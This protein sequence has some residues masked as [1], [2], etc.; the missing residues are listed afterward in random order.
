MKTIYSLFLL[1]C[2][3]TLHSQITLESTLDL[4]AADNN[5]TGMSVVVTCGDEVQEI[6]HHGLRNIEQNLPVNDDT[7]FRIAS[8]SKM[9]TAVGM[10]HLLDA[11]AYN[12]DDDVNEHLSFE[13]RNPAFPDTPITVRQVLSHQTGITDGDGYFDFLSAT[14]NAAEI[15]NL[16]ELLTPEG[17]YYT[18]DMFTANEAGTYFSYSNINSGLCATLLESISGERFDTY[19]KTNILEPLGIGGSFRVNDLT[20]LD[21]LS[22]LYRNGA[23]QWDNYQGEYPA[24]AD[25]SDY[26]PGTNGVYFAPQGGLR[27]SALELSDIMQMI[28]HGGTWNG[29][30]VLQPAT[31]ELMLTPEWTYNGS[32][33]N[34]YF[35]LFNS[36][37]LGIQRTLNTPGGDIVIPGSTCY[38]HAGEAYGLISDAYYSPE[39]DM[40]IVVIINGYYGSEYYSFGNMSAF[41]QPEEDVF[42]AINLF[43]TDACATTSTQAA[44]DLNLR[45]SPNPATDK[46]QFLCPER[47]VKATAADVTGR[48]FLL[49]VIGNEADIS[50]LAAGIY[51]LRLDTES[52]VRVLRKLVKTGE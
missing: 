35:N 51:V 41:Y 26:V 47:I 50:A 42:N 19:I 6:Y 38:G 5:L 25:L 13:L 15:P 43:L 10:M 46:V 1:C 3:I 14:Y 11:G 49:H 9:V 4:A 24:P 18:A 28:A 16:S 22:V 39:D 2:A 48:D 21:N 34:N 12:L 30:T 20:D 45:V 52:G 44:A 31:V 27:V 37:G 7:R 40:T 32:N 23:P 17:S 8:I 36:W 29:A 33:G